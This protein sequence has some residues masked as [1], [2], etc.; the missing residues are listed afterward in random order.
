MELR[1]WKIQRNVTLVFVRNSLAQNLLAVYTAVYQSLRSSTVLLAYF[2]T[3]YAEASTQP[4]RAHTVLDALA[5]YIGP[6]V[7]CTSIKRGIAVRNLIPPLALASSLPLSPLSPS[8]TAKQE[9]FHSNRRDEQQPVR[10]SK[11]GGRKKKEKKRGEEKG[12]E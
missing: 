6:P 11:P 3:F 8:C 4:I 10:D 12:A 5:G 1:D 2:L 9:Q 7:V